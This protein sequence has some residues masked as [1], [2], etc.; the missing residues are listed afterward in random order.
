MYV[1]NFLGYTNKTGIKFTAQI[2]N[3][4]KILILSVSLQAEGIKYTNRGHHPQ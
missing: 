2:T 1:H 3:N 4:I